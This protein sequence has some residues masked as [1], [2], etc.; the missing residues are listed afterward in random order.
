MYGISYMIS[1]ICHI[2]Y[3]QGISSYVFVGTIY[4]ISG[5]LFSSHLLLKV[6][7]HRTGNQGGK[8]DAVGRTKIS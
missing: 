6:E 8:M 3:V 7:V 4:E 2:V 5:K 1:H